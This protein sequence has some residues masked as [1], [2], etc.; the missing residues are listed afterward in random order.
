MAEL[1]FTL[2]KAVFEFVNHSLE[3]RLFDIL[4]PFITDLNR[5]T[6]ALV[7]VGLALVFWFIKGGRNARLAILLLVPT[8]ALSDQLSSSVVKFILERPRPCHVLPDVHLLVSCGSGY[9]FPSSHA[10]NSFAGALVISFFFPR[11]AWSWFLYAS[12][13]AFSRVYVGV[14][15]PAD[16]IGGAVIGLGCGGFVIVAFDSVEKTWFRKPKRVIP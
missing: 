4:M 12:V 3:N 14:H 9:A 10:V 7:V 6:P 2:D 11:T 13:V 8:I 16:V 5:N 15:Y 1:L